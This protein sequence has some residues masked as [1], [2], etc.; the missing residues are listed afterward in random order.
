MTNIDNMKTIEELK[1]GD[2]TVIT[3]NGGNIKEFHG[4]YSEKWNCVFFAIPSTYEI[5]G[6]LQ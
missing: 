3:K 1:E 2:C 4:S 6:Y 5:I